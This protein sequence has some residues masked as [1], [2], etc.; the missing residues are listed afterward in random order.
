MET[1]LLDWHQRKVPNILQKTFPNAFSRI[2]IIILWFKFHC[3]GGVTYNCNRYGCVKIHISLRKDAIA[4]IG[5]THPPN[6]N[7]V[8][9]AWEKTHEMT[10]YHPGIS[11]WW[12][13]IRARFLSLAR[14]KLRLCS[15]NHRPGYWSNL[16]CDWPEH[17]LSL[18][19]TRDKKTGPGIWAETAMCI[20]GQVR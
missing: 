5:M 18:L 7:D 11:P 15:A 19:R 2:K 17:S 12:A 8:Q 20:I 3:D 6:V 1:T 13:W 4:R 9:F 16:P 10:I 14:R